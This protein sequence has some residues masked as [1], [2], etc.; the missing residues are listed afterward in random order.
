MTG[1][2]LPLSC[3][4]MPQS[5]S[6]SD[7]VLPGMEELQS[8]SDL[9]GEE[10]P[11]TDSA[12]VSL[13]SPGFLSENQTFSVPG[14]LPGKADGEVLLTCPLPRI[15]TG[16]HVYLTIPPLMGKGTL[17]LNSEHLLSFCSF[18][19]AGTEE[20]ITCRKE[21]DLSEMLIPERM[22]TLELRF[23]PF[24][25]AG[26]CDLFVLRMVTSGRI[27]LTS[28]KRSRGKIS[29]TFLVTAYSS[30]SYRIRISGLNTV[31]TIV[32]MHLSF[33]GPGTQTIPCTLPLLWNETVYYRAQFTDKSAVLDSLTIPAGHSPRRC[34]YAL[35][36]P[37][38]DAVL[39]PPDL[40][41]LLNRIGNPPVFSPLPLSRSCVEALTEAGIPLILPPDAPAVPPEYEIHPGIRFDTPPAVLCSGAASAWQLCGLLLSP[42]PVPPERSVPDLLEEIF[43]RKALAAATS[44]PSHL[45]KLHLLLVRLHAE[46]VRQG[47]GSG[48]LCSAAEW[49]DS[50]VL[51]IL[52]DVFKAGHLSL[53]PLQ[54]ASFISS[55]LVFSVRVYLPEDCTSVD[56]TA[57]LSLTRPDG[58]SP[59]YEDTLPVSSLIS[60]NRQ[61]RVSLPD[62]PCI[63]RLNGRL[64]LEGSV[65]DSVSV[66]VCV[67][68]I[69]P[70][71]QLLLHP[72]SMGDL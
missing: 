7:F 67:G 3:W 22:N 18:P 55:V 2:L 16:L 69:A 8:F 12:A 10:N 6:S 68:R 21:L 62:T 56:G 60:E 32:D 51:D 50:A 11:D 4:Q 63:C 36:V 42:R 44:L 9:W 66:P 41:R 35:S 14:L 70:L 29:C 37:A 24:R 47:L 57:E 59:L 25:P 58:K 1:K 65:I 52:S 43:G 34:D 26:I 39:Y 19:E 5:G 71:E 40:V 17:S 31:G 61:I 33:P 54:G 72:E 20:P 15:E 45:A 64:I 48:A 13:P 38:W 23:E 28:A 49:D 53:A 46:L 30:G 27:E